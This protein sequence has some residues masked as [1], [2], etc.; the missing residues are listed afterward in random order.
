MNIPAGHPSS[1]QST[2]RAQPSALRFLCWGA[3]TLAFMLCLA[4]ALFQAWPLSGF[5]F[6]LAAGSV[7]IGLALLPSPP[8]RP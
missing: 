3:G 7:A 4:A 6:A 2:R 5:Y 1:L 8:E